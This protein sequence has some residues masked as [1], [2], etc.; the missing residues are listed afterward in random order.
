MRLQYWHCGDLTEEAIKDFTFGRR[1]SY[2]I[3]NHNGEYS[4]V[5]NDYS[6]GTSSG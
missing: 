2:T 3:Y 1:I 5:Q 4:L 6:T